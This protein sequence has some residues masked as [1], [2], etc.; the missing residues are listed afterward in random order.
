MGSQERDGAVLSMDQW[1]ANVAGKVNAT[2]DKPAVIVFNART[3]R[4]HQLRG[5]E[6]K[7]H[8]QAEKKWSA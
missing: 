7:R 2:S 3:Q 6:L 5:K 1:F 8:L 4:W